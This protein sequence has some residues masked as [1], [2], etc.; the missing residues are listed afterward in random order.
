MTI[1]MLKTVIAAAGAVSL[2]GCAHQDGAG[3][4]TATLGEAQYTLTCTK[5]ERK[6]RAQ[7]RAESAIYMPQPVRTAGRNW[8]FEP[9]YRCSV[10][11]ADVSRSG[12][13]EGI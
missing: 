1:A 3:E 7:R 4:A 13:E 6:L 9:L 5:L 10:A 12:G 8:E 2:I 11:D